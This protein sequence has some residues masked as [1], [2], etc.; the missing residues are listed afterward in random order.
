MNDEHTETSGNLVK[1]VLDCTKCERICQCHNPKRK[2]K[3]E[4]IENELIKA[5]WKFVD[6]LVN[7]VNR[8]ADFIVKAS[9]KLLK[10]F[11]RSN[12]RKAYKKA[13]F[14]KAFARRVSRMLIA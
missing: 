1:C 8:L 7:L 3:W 9:C 6:S 10:I 13:R 12:R 4:G 5:F 14:K 11:Q 2:E